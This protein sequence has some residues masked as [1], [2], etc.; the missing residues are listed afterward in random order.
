MV[1]NHRPARWD[2]RLLILGRESVAA[3][4]ELQGFQNM[5]RLAFRRKR[6]AKLPTMR[7]SIP[8]RDGLLEFRNRRKA[9]ELPFTGLAQQKAGQIIHVD[10]LHDNC[11]CGNRFRFL[12]NPPCGVEEFL[13]CKRR[14]GTTVRP[15]EENC[16]KLMLKV[17]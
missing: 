1:L 12:D 13:T 9:E 15:F 3:D 5:D 8:K 4:L 7:M 11:D 10:A 2:W 14:S 17:T 16:S 6:L